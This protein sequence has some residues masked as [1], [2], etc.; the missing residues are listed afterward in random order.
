LGLIGIDR[1]NREELNEDNEASNIVY[2]GDNFGIFNCGVFS[3][4][5]GAR[6]ISGKGRSS[7]G[8]G[9]K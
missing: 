6:A 2:G 7:I 4:E 8:R 5:C 1:E 9:V 3:V